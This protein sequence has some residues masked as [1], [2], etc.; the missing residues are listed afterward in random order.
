M[1]AASLEAGLTRATGATG[2]VTLIQRLGSALNFNVHFHTLFLDGVYRADGA[3]WPVFRQVSAPDRVGL[4]LLV[5][6]IAARVGEALERRGRLRRTP[7]AAEERHDAVLQA[8]GQTPPRSPAPAPPGARMR[9]IAS[10]GA[11]DAGVNPT[12]GHVSEDM[13]H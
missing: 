2:A 4:Q 12:S 13:C 3:H 6:K 7:S 5:E 11:R 1:R 10:V 9:T 8:H